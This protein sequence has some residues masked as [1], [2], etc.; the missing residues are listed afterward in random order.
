[1]TLIDEYWASKCKPNCGKCCYFF[2]GTVRTNIPCPHLDEGTKKCLVYKQRDELRAKGEIPW[3][4][5]VTPQTIPLLNLPA[6]CG[7]LE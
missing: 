2:V 7:Y 6:D 4:N 3:C 5:D 1:M